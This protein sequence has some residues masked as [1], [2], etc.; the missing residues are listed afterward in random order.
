MQLGLRTGTGSRRLRGI[1]RRRAAT[2]MTPARTY[3]VPMSPVNGRRPDPRLRFTD[4]AG[5]PDGDFAGAAVPNGRL[6]DDMVPASGCT[7]AAVEELALS[8]DGYAYWSDVAELGNRSLQRWTRDR[9][10]PAT[11]DELRG[12]LFYEQRRWHHF[13]EEPHGRGAEYVR[14]LLESIRSHLAPAPAPPELPTPPVLPP[15]PRPAR[16]VDDPTPAAGTTTVAVFSDDDRGYG[17]WAS[18]HGDGFVLNAPK[19]SSAKGLRLHKATCSSV[20]TAT[21]STRSPTASVRKVC[22]S[23]VAPLLEWCAATLDAEPEPCR[24]CRP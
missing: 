22:A 19:G 10:V 20:A 13:G 5:A 16:T 3:V 24:R 14:A 2:A 12:C 21:S 4:P 9:T 8:Y 15:P 18:A 6:R 11:L 17:A 1:L 7:W 23:D